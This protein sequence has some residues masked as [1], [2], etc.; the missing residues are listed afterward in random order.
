MLAFDTSFRKDKHLNTSQ[1]VQQ[2]EC[3]Y[4]VPTHTAK[5]QA[6][7]SNAI[8]SNIITLLIQ[9]HTSFLSYLWIAEVM[10]NHLAASLSPSA[11]QENRFVVL[12]E[13]ETD[14]ELVVC[15]TIS[16]IKINR[17]TSTIRKSQTTTYK[18]LNEGTYRNQC[19]L[20]NRTA[21]KTRSSSLQKVT[22]EIIITPQ[23]AEMSKE[24][25]QVLFLPV[26]I[27]C[28]NKHTTKEYNSYKKCLESCLSTCTLAYPC[29]RARDCHSSS[30]AHMLQVRGCIPYWAPAA[31]AKQ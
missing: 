4:F 2:M 13:M 20:L 23:V 22:P 6:F 1:K 15:H 12:E 14:T 3:P 5:Y 28:A 24:I 11:V 29:A 7:L 8:C 18:T 19:F 30:A 21:L 10:V 31:A 26:F 27:Y 25:A 16:N 17:A 9:C